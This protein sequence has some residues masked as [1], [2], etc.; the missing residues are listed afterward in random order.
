MPMSPFQ[1]S[2]DEVQQMSQQALGQSFPQ[3]AKVDPHDSLTVPIGPPA[4]EPIT[5]APGA[6]KGGDSEGKMSL[7]KP[8]EDND[9]QKLMAD[10]KKDSD[11]YGSP[12]NHPGFG[13]KLL[14][15]LSVVGNTLGDIIAPH[16]MSRIPGTQLHRQVE[17][18]QLQGNLQNLSKQESEEGLQGAQAS[19]QTASANKDIAETPEIAPNAAASREHEGAETANLQSEAAE[20]NQNAE[21][22]PSL[23]QGLCPCGQ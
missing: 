16:T 13:G 9:S 21:M 7:L 11:P 17:E 23:I 14:H 1:M 19:N 20:R 3:M 10:Y 8:Q 15:G 2:P 18:Q 22:G 5:M 12:D 4:P 6:K